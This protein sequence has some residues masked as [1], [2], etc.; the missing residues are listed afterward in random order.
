MT[1]NAPTPWHYTHEGNSSFFIRD[2]SGRGLIWMGNSSA[3]QQGENEARCVAICR[4]VNSH[5]ELVEVLQRLRNAE[6][7]PRQEWIDALAN[8]DAALAKAGK[9]EG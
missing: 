4:S 2:A 6:K 7:A 1:P 3:F 8:A 9:G 5:D